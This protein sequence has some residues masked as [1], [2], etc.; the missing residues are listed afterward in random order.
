MQN[1][2]IVSV[3]KIRKSDVTLRGKWH[4]RKMYYF[5]TAENAE[6]IINGYEKD[7][8]QYKDKITALNT[9]LAQLREK[10]NRDGNFTIPTG[11]KYGGGYGD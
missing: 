10:P 4:G 3:P 6:T 8:Q 11:N 9:E 1:F 5:L 2:I 7:I